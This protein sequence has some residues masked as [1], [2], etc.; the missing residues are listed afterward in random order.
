MN[1]ENRPKAEPSAPFCELIGFRRDPRK[2]EKVDFDSFDSWMDEQLKLLEAKF[3]HNVTQN[4]L[5]NEF[6]SGR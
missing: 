1:K 2:T 3:A 4:S 5:R 6:H